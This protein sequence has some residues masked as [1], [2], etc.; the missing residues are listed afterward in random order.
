TNP[1]ADIEFAPEIAVGERRKRPDFRIRHIGEQWSYVEVTQPSSSDAQ[2][3]A[4]QILDRLAQLLRP[5]MKEFSLEIYLDRQ[6]TEEELL[7]L[8]SAVPRFCTLEGVCSE[9]LDKSLGLLSLN[10]SR[11]CK[12]V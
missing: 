5:I 4:E 9:D 6:P 2:R 10:Y 11:P 7:L 12:V 3:R 8:E 1:N